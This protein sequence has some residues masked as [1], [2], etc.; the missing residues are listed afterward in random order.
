MARAVESLSKRSELDREISFAAL[1]L[2]EKSDIRRLMMMGLRAGG[3]PV[4][5]TLMFLSLSLISNTGSKNF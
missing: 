2:Y 4:T 1:E 3:L 5:N